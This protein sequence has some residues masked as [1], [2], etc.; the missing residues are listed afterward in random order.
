MDKKTPLGWLRHTEGTYS[1]RMPVK[2][3]TQAE[4]TESTSRNGATE[5][6]GPEKAVSPHG[7]RT[8]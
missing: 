4:D 2:G 5:E 1:I 6:R 3:E 8:R 7:V